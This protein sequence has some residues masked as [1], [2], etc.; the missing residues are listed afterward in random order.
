M[1]DNSSLKERDLNINQSTILY[2]GSLGRQDKRLI[3]QASDVPSI[4]F[5]LTI[6]YRLGALKAL[7]FHYKE[8]LGTSDAWLMSPLSRRPSEPAYYIED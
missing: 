4:I 5:F 7:Y 3:N 2:A 6:S 8:I 1:V